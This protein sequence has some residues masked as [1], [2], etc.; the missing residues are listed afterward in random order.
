MNNVVPFPGE[1]R[2]KDGSGDGGGPEDP[3]LE[4][5]V[6]R[7]EADMSEIK[8]TLVKLDAKFDKLDAKFD[9][10]LG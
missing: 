4:Q 6:A 7:L 8:S 2:G 9:G 3:M 5:R 10:K 1:P